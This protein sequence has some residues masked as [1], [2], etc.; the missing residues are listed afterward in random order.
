ML[1]RGRRAGEAEHHGRSAPARY[2][3]ALAADLLFH[4]GDPVAPS[5]AI[6][7]N[8]DCPRLDLNLAPV[9]EYLGI[10]FE[11]ANRESTHDANTNG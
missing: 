10:L 4:V 11:W 2:E 6:S 1:R 3:P 5:A 9:I 7:G 8:G